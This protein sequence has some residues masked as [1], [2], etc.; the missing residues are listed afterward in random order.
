MRVVEATM[1]DGRGGVRWVGWRRATK[2][3][4]GGRRLRLGV[5][6]SPKSGGGGGWRGKVVEA[7]MDGG[8]G[9][10]RRGQRRDR[11]DGRCRLERE[12]RAAAID[13]DWNGISEPPI[14]G[15]IGAALETRFRR[16]PPK[17]NT[18]P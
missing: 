1:D 16:R 14:F 6:W 10:V 11:G 5:A 8:Y 7:A 3:Q 13:A 9:G 15:P 12:Q 2:R 18:G 4:A 17:N